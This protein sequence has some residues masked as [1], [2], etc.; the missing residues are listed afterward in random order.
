MK[1]A[2]VVVKT[3]PSGDG[4][5]LPWGWVPQSLDVTFNQCHGGVEAQNGESP[6]QVN[7]SVLYCLPGRGI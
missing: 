4:A 6:S 7:D 3:G 2:W 5:A 1:P